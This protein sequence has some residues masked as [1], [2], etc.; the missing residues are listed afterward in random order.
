MTTSSDDLARFADLL[1]RHGSDRSRWPER[2]RVFAET[3]LAVSADARVA[4]DHAR[5]L[6]AWLDDAMVAPAPDTR[7][8]RNR[9][10]AALP[11]RDGFARF[12]DWLRRGPLLWRPVAVALVPLVLGFLVGI[13]APDLLGDD[14]DIATELSLFAFVATEEYG[15]AQ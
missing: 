4:F 13:G 1:D 15:D 3:L 6:D 5:T 10:L 2:E 11:N 14:N 9:I 12:F 8:L 7:V